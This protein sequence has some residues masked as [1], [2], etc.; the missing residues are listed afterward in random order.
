[1]DASFWGF[2]SS[3]AGT[4]DVEFMKPNLCEKEEAHLGSAAVLCLK[5]LLS[6]SCLLL[7]N[8]EIV[9][10]AGL[11]AFFFFRLLRRSRV[12]RKPVNRCLFGRDHLTSS[13]EKGQPVP[14]FCLS[15]GKTRHS[16]SIAVPVSVVVSGAF[17]LGSGPDLLGM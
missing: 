11:Q 15:R 1:M 8:R 12:A 3:G 9:N 7:T 4:S 10:C 16:V 13:G 14:I 6:S 5:S 2:L 17:R